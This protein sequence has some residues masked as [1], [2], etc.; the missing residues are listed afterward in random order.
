MGGRDRPTSSSRDHEGIAGQG[1]QGTHACTP[2]SS[3]P[4][5]KHSDPSVA[6]QLACASGM[7]CLEQGRYR[8]AAMKLTDVALDIG[9]PTNEISL[10]PQVGW[11]A[12]VCE[13]VCRG[14]EGVARSMLG[15][16]CTAAVPSLQSP[17]LKPA[18]L[19]PS[20]PYNI[21]QPIRP[22]LTPPCL[23]RHPHPPSSP[24]DVA[25]YG[26][27]C[28]MAALSRSELSAR[29]VHNVAFREFLELVPEVCVGGGSRLCNDETAPH[30]ESRV[31][32]PLGAPH[33]LACGP[34]GARWPPVAWGCAA[35]AC[36]LGSRPALL[37]NRPWLPTLPTA[38]VATHRRRGRLWPTSMPPATPRACATWRR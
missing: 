32:C 27:L 34:L 25:I 2:R 5:Q 16:W 17:Q 35:P 22:L 31:S 19:P 30:A 29:L 12:Y 23:P 33:P 3:R 24:Q 4:A 7:Y 1:A 36:L 13:C 10:A 14:G 11:G 37:I 26:T 28:G 18:L 20:N 21:A 8:A 15:A 38:V 6:S 9:L